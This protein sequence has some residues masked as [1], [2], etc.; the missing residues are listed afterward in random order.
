M[1]DYNF[2]S[3]Y[4]ESKSSTSNKKQIYI[5]SMITAVILLAFSFYLYNIY[6]LQS[7]KE[8]LA[9]I[10]KF[11]LSDSTQKSLEQYKLIEEKVQK[12]NTYQHIIKNAAKNIDSNDKINTSLL[13]NISGAMPKN[14]FLKVMNISSETV[15]LNG[16]ASNRVAVAEFVYNLKN[17]G[18]FRIV[19]IGNI[20]E[21]GEDGDS[22]IFT[23]VCKSEGVSDYEAK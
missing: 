16:I 17:N 19:H 15:Q 9:K 8:E 18:V 14:V 12:L 3:P 6:K 11:L 21:E 7:I 4:I 22:Y 5:I 20:S 2:F 10:D 1:R 13:E 23:L